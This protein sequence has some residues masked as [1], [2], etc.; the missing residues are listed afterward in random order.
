MDFNE[1]NQE[2]KVAR[3]RLRAGEIGPVDEVQRRLRELAAGLTGDEDRRVAE[4]L[5]AGLPDAVAPARAASPELIE[6]RS[7][8]DSDDLDRGSKEERLAAIDRAR[9]EIWAIADR[10]GDDSATIRALTRMLD[11][12]EDALVEGLPWDDPPPGNT[13]SA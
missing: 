11:R 5:V 6:A 2:F 7:I 12:R 9:K 3:S 4:G 1:F 8:L 13:P 10:A